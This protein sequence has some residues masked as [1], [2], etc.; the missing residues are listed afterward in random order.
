LATLGRALQLFGL[1]LL[2]AA[3]LYGIE[4]EGGRAVGIELTALAVGAVA[5]VL[6]TKLLQ[7][8]R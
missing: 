2:P 7:R 3:L 8:G 1:I 5:F 4:N 6:G